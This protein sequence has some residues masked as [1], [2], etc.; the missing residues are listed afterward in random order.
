MTFG[1][2]TVARPMSLGVMAKILA[3]TRWEPDAYGRLAQAASELFAERG[4][5][6]TTVEDIA[7]RAGLT[8]RTFFRHF[9]DKREV[10][11]A[12]G[13]EFKERFVRTLAAVPAEVAPLEAVAVSLEAAGA[14]LQTRAV[15]ARERQAIIAANPELQ[16]RELVKLA[17]ISAALAASLRERGVEEPAASLTAEA[18]MG[19]FR[20]AFEQW[21]TDPAPKP[22][23]LPARIRESLDALRVVAA[24]R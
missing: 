7:A 22:R 23:D 6:Q 3:V 4:F 13:E 17:G 12:G 15:F 8:K 11:F 5:E 20:V 2:I 9:A 24:A 19:V 18:G 10:L 1:V 16:E 14:A 21:V